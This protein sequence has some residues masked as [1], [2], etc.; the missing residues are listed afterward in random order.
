WSRSAT[1]SWW[2]PPCRPRSA[3]SSSSTSPDA[4]AGWTR[5]GAAACT[6]TPT[7][8]R[9]RFALPRGA[10]WTPTSTTETPRA[11][12]A[13]PDGGEMADNGSPKTR[14][15]IV[16]G[17]FAGVACARGLAKHDD[18]A[19]TLVDKNDYHQFQPLLYQVATSM[20]AARDIAYPLWRIAAEYQHFESKR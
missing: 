8:D 14:V 5:S 13:A 20:L 6:S 19:V 2:T 12:R 15:V 9:P 10:R 7:S 16:G 11:K 18:I 3:T 4:G 17:G 1:T